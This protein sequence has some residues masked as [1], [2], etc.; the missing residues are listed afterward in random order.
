M[1]KCIIETD[2]GFI[3]GAG[4]ANLWPVGWVDAGTVILTKT[5]I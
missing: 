4:T 3:H 2:P 1:S 5:G